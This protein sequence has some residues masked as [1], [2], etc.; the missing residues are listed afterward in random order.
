[1]PITFIKD[2]DFYEENGKVVFTEHFL[3]NRGFC[4]GNYCKHCPY[5]IDIQ[6]AAAGKKCQSLGTNLPVE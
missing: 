2:I 1:M 4:C 3:L 6:D 5:G